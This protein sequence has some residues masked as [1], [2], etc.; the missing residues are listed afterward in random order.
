M[1]SEVHIEM[2]EGRYSPAWSLASEARKKFVI[3]H[4]CP[5][6]ISF[7]FLVISAFLKS[8]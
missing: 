6:K 1:C 2:I 5:D 8:L 3:W 7:P 4:V